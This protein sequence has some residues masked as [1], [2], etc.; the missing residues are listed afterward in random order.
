MRRDRVLLAFMLVYAAASLTHFVHNAVYIDAYPKLPAWVTPLVVYASWLVI[1]AIGALGYW[2]C[3]RG[4]RR[5]GLALIGVYAAL[6]FGGLDHYTLAPVSAHTLTMNATLLGA[7]IAASLLL[8]VVVW[9]GA[10]SSWERPSG[11]GLSSD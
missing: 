3:R 6:G 10:H 4:S 9:I 7:V 8:V 5:V 1:V 11:R 2:S